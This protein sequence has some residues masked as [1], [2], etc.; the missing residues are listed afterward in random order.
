MAF[1]RICGRA[2]GD[3][4]ALFAPRHLGV[5]R[6]V[7]GAQGDDDVG[8]AGDDGQLLGAVIADEHPILAQGLLVLGGQVDD[9][10]DTRQVR[11]QGLAHRLGLGRLRGGFGSGRWGWCN[12][13]LLQIADQG[14]EFGLVEQAELVRGH[15]FAAGPEALTLEQGDIV[16]EL[17]D[18]LVAF[19]QELLGFGQTTL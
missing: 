6:G 18:A 13:L 17:F 3:A 2:R 7:L 9:P 4:D 1:G 10:L 14:F 15:P 11:G 12:D 19:G 8:L 16:Q 5:A